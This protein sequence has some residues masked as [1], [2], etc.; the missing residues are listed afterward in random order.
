MTL[1]VR[2]TPA[3]PVIV[4]ELAGGAIA[5]HP[6]VAVPIADARRIAH[7]LL[8]AATDSERDIERTGG[9]APIATGITP[10]RGFAGLPSDRQPGCPGASRAQRRSVPAAA[11]AIRLHPMRHVFL[12][13]ADDGVAA[14]PTFIFFTREQLRDLA[15]TLLEALNKGA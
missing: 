10:D 5:H 4:D 9:V 6:Q 13:E 2:R 11:P 12:I 14:V 3:G 7:G 8:D 1:A 15:Q